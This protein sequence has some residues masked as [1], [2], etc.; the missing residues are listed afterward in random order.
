LCDVDVC[1]SDFGLAR[2]GRDESGLTLSG[3]IVGTPGYMSPEQI[4]SE[5]PTPAGDVYGLG[6]VLYECLTGQPPSRAATPL[7]TLLRTL[8]HEPLPPR[9]LSSHI[10]RDLETVCLKCLESEPQQRYSSASALADDLERWLRGEPVRARRIGPLARAWRWSR[11]KP[12]VAILLAALVLTMLEGLI[13]IL[14]QWRSAEAARREAEV[15]DAQTQHL[16]NELLPSSPGAPLLMPYSQK[17]PSIDALIK[18]EAHFAG[19]LEK[20]PSDTK[21][22]IALSNVRGTLG[23]LCSLQGRLAEMEASF[24]GARDLW[25][26]MAH[27][28]P[29][30]FLYRERL[31]SALYWQSLAAAK[32]EDR[33]RWMRLLLQAG[34]LWQ[35]LAEEQPGN[36]VVL[37]KLADLRRILLVLRNLG[38][39]WDETLPPLEEERALLRK[40]VGEEPA[41][42]ALR[43]RLAL[44]CLVLGEYHF[45]QGRMREALPCWREAYEHG[46]KLVGA[47]SDDP[48]VELSLALCCS[49]LMAGQPTDPYYTEAVGL[50]GQTAGRLAALTHQHP[51]E[52]WLRYALLEAHC[53]LAVCHWNA[54][55]AAEAEHSFHKQVRP[56]AERM[57]QQPGNQQQTFSVLHFLLRAAGSLRDK[58][59]P[60]VLALAREAATF[61][62]RCADSPSRDLEYCEQ[63]ANQS[64]GI[65]A[66]LC[67]LEQPAESLRLAEQGRRLYEG[68][69]RGVPAVPGYGHGLSS[70]WERIAKACWELGRRD[71]ALAAFRK[72]AAVQRE[73]VGQAPSAREYRLSLSRC[74]DR[75]AF[76]GGRAGDRPTVAAALRELEKLWPDDTEALLEVARD[77]EKL[78]EAVGES[79]KQLTS[80]EKAERQRYL[81]ESERARRAAEVQRTTGKGRQR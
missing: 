45:G 70:A 52:E 79:R 75:L 54:G 3:A 63:L 10:D 32:Q 9:L 39:G 61:A 73:V 5:K 30:S 13:G 71:E 47:Q 72:S 62:E 6:A 80:E 24:Q 77:F 57:S 51:N 26:T 55:R 4:R 36:L 2:R 14:Y 81:A 35:E 66:L 59:S 76:W 15:S 56:L 58:K 65:A 74:Y 69:R 1:V 53:F 27:Q 33:G 25:E 11:R 21:V 78:A 38:P 67:R 48:L 29:Q 12:L 44:T 64:V 41:T 17:L 8:Q 49:R 23:T 68:L 18:A 31:A 16:L 50:L 19:L 42:V 40:R 20:R 46:R 22:R 60:A 7:D 28:E 37:Q 43:K 34:A